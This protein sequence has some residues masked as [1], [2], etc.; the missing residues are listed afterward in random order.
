MLFASEL[1]ALYATFSSVCVSFC[2]ILKAER[3]RAHGINGSLN[4]NMVSR[5]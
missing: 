2:P 1:T 4:A 3:K 5:E